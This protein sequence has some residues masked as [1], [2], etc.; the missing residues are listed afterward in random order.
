[1]IRLIVALL[2][3]TVFGAIFAGIYYA[4]DNV[5]F[6][7]DGVPAFSLAA[8]EARQTTLQPTI[9]G[10]PIV[11]EVRSFGGPFDLYVMEAEWSDP[12]AGDGR[13]SLDQPFSYLAEH[14]AIGLTGV[15]EFVLPSDGITSYV[16]V[17]DNSDAYYLDDTQ[18]DPASPTNGTVSVQLT[19]RY[20]EEE[21][22]SLVLGYIAAVP[23]IALVAITLVRKIRHHRARPKA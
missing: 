10:T 22:R 11:V 17:F 5:H 14:S 20:L 19:V 9:A 16:L 23:S 12:L 1:M 15:T 4:P 13:L 2:G 8:G 21:T 3:F 7:E 6:K 18:P